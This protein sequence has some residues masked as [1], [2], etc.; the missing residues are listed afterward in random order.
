MKPIK[1]RGKDILTG[2]TV[3]GIGFLSS[4][5]SSDYGHLV[6]EDLKDYSV[7]RK[8]VAQFL[9]YDKNGKEIYSDDRIRVYNYDHRRKVICFRAMNAEDFFTFSDI[10]QIFNDIELLEE[11]GKNEN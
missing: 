1:F 9:G 3:Y 6:D 11:S 8:S 10:G 2:K 5:L 4:A 7:Q